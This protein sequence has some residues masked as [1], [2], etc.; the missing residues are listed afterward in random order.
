[1]R[2]LGTYDSGG[3]LRISFGGHPVVDEDVASLAR[4]W[5]REG[6]RA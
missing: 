5:K 2:R 6:E 1:M 4:A 3:R